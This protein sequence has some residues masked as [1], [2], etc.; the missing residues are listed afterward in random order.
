MFI[1]TEEEGKGHG[2]VESGRRLRMSMFI[3][4]LAMGP[5]PLCPPF[6][7]AL[8][9]QTTL[10]KKKRYPCAVFLTHGTVIHFFYG[11]SPG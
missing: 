5:A 3:H 9:Q 11:Y 1:N 10:T 7:F 2:E 8:L 6:T 4:Q